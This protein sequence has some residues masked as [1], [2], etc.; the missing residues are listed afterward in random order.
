MFRLKMIMNYVDFTWIRYDCVRIGNNEVGFMW[1]IHG[2]IRHINIS[3]I[4]YSEVIQTYMSSRYTVVCA[5]K[6][7][8]LCKREVGST[9]VHTR[10]GVPSCMHVRTHHVA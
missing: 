7:Q 2:F 3:P 9:G 5:Y 8:R 10:S 6:L 1:K 4:V